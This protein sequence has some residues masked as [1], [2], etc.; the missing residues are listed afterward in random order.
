MSQ[1]LIFLQL[2]MI[3]LMKTLPGK[4]YL[5]FR[6]FLYILCYQ[7]Q[8]ILQMYLLIPVEFT[9]NILFIGHLPFGAQYLF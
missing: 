6:R 7:E 5:L 4:N 9:N 8:L 2:V 3:Q 1:I